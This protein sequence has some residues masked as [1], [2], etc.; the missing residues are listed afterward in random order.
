MA[1]AHRRLLAAPVAE[2]QSRARWV[3]GSTATD[4]S[5]ATSCL[6]DG[7]PARTQQLAGPTRR[8]AIGRHAG[9]H[10]DHFPRSAGLRLRRVSAA[11]GT[12]AVLVTD[13][14]RRRLRDCHSRVR[15]CHH[16]VGR[17][18]DH[19]GS[20]RRPVFS[21]KRMVSAPT[22]T[23]AAARRLVGPLRCCRPVHAAR[24]DLGAH[25]KVKCTRQM[26][27]SRGARPWP[28]TRGGARPAGG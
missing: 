13:R 21:W 24:L 11:H 17:S 10:R 7:T 20:S 1:A 14:P 15:A 28:K 4:W 5:F 19:H 23:A 22:P 25:R 8:L 12:G 9:S 6:S 18:L 3:R 27:V 26:I 16:P 2:A